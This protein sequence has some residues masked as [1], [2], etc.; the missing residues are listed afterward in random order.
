M[1]GPLKMAPGGQKESNKRKEKTT[2]EIAIKLMGHSERWVKFWWS[3]ERKPGPT[4]YRGCSG[5]GN[6][7]K[8]PKCQ[9]NTQSDVEGAGQ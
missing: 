3:Q 6:R 5:E 8:C 7:E 9:K 2:K 1:A 4:S